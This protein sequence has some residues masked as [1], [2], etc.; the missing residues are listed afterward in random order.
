MPLTIARIIQK[1]TA[2][3]VQLWQIEVKNGISR[4]KT[5][6]PKAAKTYH[7][8]A[9]TLTSLK[10]CLTAVVVTKTISKTVVMSWARAMPRSVRTLA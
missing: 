8:S 10:T 6:M 2:I 9:R 1:V 5:S 3:E 7:L 4:K